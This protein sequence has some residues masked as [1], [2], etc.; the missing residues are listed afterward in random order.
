MDSMLR[1]LDGIAKLVDKRLVEPAFSAS[2]SKARSCRIP[3]EAR[4]PPITCCRRQ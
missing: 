2:T 1:S 3:S 4:I